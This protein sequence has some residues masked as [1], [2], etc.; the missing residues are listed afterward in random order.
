[1]TKVGYI[2]N[3]LEPCK[4][5][6][7]STSSNIKADFNIPAGSP[8]CLML[9]G[10]KPMKGHVFLLKSFKLVLTKMP[11]VHL[12]ICG[13]GSQ[14]EIAQVTK[15]VGILGLSRN[16]HLLGFRPNA[17]ELLSQADVLLCASQS[18]ESFGLT[19]VEAMM[20]KIPVVVTAVGGVP[21]VVVDN[22]G[23]YCLPKDDVVGYAD[24]IVA[25]LSDDKLRMQQG[26]KGFESAS[27]LFAAQVMAQKYYNYL[28][29]T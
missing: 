10:Y 8:L 1:M 23:G 9:G 2:Y 18:F 16:V 6:S 13:H 19:S 11:K 17:I 3:G 15:L 25:L 4:N 27:R 29:T 5:D 28:T 14:E 12:I 26:Q 7:I 20:Q 22:E 24:R 21:E